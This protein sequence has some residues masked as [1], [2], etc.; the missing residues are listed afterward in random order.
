MIKFFR[1]IRHT[2]ITENKMGK[3]FKY[4]IG[5]ILLVMVGILLALQVNNWNEDRK[6]QIKEK[7]TLFKFSQDLKSDSVYYQINMRRVSSIDSLHKEL[8]LVGFKGK[9]AL[10]HSKPSYIRRALAYVPVAK[11][12]D[13]NITNKINNKDI[14][15]EIQAYFRTMGEALQAT[16]EFEKVVFEI[17]DFLRHH[18]IH[19]VDYWFKSEM[20]ETSNREVPEYIVS[21]ASLIKLSE[22][23]DFQ[24]LLFESS[25]KLN[26][27][28][29][30]LTKLINENTRLISKIKKY[31]GDND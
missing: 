31:I 27:S 21:K 14:R 15:E 12:N 18:K 22:N 10:E 25:V 11:E 29:H 13:P 2:L 26:E 23:E 17:R 30:T 16:F 19:N 9:E 3:Y 5:E 28:K 6:A 8:Y 20:L 7:A 24:Q 1:H 4:A